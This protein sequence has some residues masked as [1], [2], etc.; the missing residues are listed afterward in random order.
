MKRFIYFFVVI[1]LTLVYS[2]TFAQTTD[3][4]DP[5]DHGVNFVDADGDGYNDN[6]PD[7]D[8][9]GVPNGLDPDYTPLG[10]QSGRGGFVDLNGDGINDNAGQGMRGSS[11]GKGGYGPKDRTGNQGVTPQD[12]TGYGAGDGTN[13]GA[14]SQTQKRR[15]KK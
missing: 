12:E 14:G 7:H 4:V 6:A 5:T 3:P 10:L 13:A 15:G 8:G 11:N 1:A 2:N 9:D